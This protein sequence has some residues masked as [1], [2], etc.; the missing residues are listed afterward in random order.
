[1]SVFISWSGQLSGKVA[2]LL[3]TWLPDVLQNVT[4]WISKE[5]IDKGSMW[6]NDLSGELQCTSVGIICVTRENRNAPWILFE[7]GALSKGVPQNRVCPL[8]IDLSFNELQPPLS[9]LNGVRPDRDDMF[10]LVS[11]INR[12]ACSCYLDD[13][14]LEKTFNQWW[15]A[16]EKE[17]QKI[18]TETPNDLKPE[19]RTVDDK[20]DELI[21]IGR[22]LHQKVTAIH[23]QEYSGSG[24]YGSGSESD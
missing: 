12:F 4:T 18:I 15:K 8:L 20:L 5:D 7:A 19:R 9:L 11:V 14:R 3:Y 2:Q 16:F 13:T 10:K 22:S 1:M 24:Y 6:F 17:F 21:L 23:E